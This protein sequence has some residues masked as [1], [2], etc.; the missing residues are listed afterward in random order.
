MGLN[1]LGRVGRVINHNIDKFIEIIIETRKDFNQKAFLYNSSG[2]DSPP[3]K[4]DR[5][6][7][8]SIDG[9]GKYV[10]VGVLTQSQKAKP[11]EKIFF[12]RDEEGKIKSVISMLGDG[13]IKGEIEKDIVYNIKGDVTQAIDG[14]FTI[15]GKKTKAEEFTGDV[16]QKA[17]SIAHEVE[18]TYNIKG[19][20]LTLE[21][22]TEII[23]KTI[24]SA[25]WFPNCIPTCPFGIPHG[26]A[27]GGITGLKGA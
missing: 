1:L 23:L 19:K 16:T 4:E 2:E 9:T 24:G 10:V 17:K 5:I 15:T 8:L 3:C 18:T 7:L 13:T 20:S 21:G 22:L 14:D 11:G 12:S 6:V 26:G 25:A 27:A